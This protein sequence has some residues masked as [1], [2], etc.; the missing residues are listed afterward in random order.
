MSDCCLVNSVNRLNYIVNRLVHA[1]GTTGA[2]GA[3]GMTGYTGPTGP[4]GPTGEVGLIGDT[5]PTGEAGFTGFTGPTGPEGGPTGDTGPTGP[6]GGPTGDTGS[7]GVTGPTG[8][9]GG[10]TGD[11][12]P[13]GP[14]GTS[15][16]ITSANGSNYITTYNFTN[17]N[18]TVGVDV[19]TTG[20]GGN[21]TTVILFDLLPNISVTYFSLVYSDVSDFG[22]GIGIYLYDVTGLTYS[23]I[24]DGTGYTGYPLATINATTPVG[25]TATLKYYE[26]VNNPI[27]SASVSSRQIALQFY[28]VGS[29]AVTVCSVTIGFG[30]VQP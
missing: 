25:D 13:T 26:G 23:S 30:I 27:I 10:P 8:P 21:G 9:F 15:E 12:G 5:G 3:A 28:G 29:G 16:I 1:S 2:T 18:G 17:N 11:T 22:T 19:S 24:G 7:T 4:T 20:T 6:A 14:T